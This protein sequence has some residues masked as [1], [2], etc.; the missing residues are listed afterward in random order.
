MR[1]RALK[2]KPILYLITDMLPATGVRLRD[3][4]D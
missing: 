3:L 1:V 2:K 4:L